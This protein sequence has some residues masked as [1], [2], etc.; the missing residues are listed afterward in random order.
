MII[1]IYTKEKPLL[2]T[3]PNFFVMLNTITIIKKLL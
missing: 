1:N 2:I 3:R